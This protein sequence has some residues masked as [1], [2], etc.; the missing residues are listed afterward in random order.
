MQ[1]AED[2]TYFMKS[3]SWSN[4]EKP[5]FGVVVSVVP[6]VPAVWRGNQML[7][8]LGSL[9]CIIIMAED[10]FSTTSIHQ[11]FKIS[12]DS[13]QVIN[14]TAAAAAVGSFG[15]CRVLGSV[16]ANVLYRSC[17]SCSVRF[18]N[19]GFVCLSCLQKVVVLLVLLL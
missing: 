9:P 7:D 16:A 13:P 12:G 15:S 2:S 4:H 8:P 5:S 10:F 18:D 6:T 19:S 14:G 17:N 11:S 3:P 1:P